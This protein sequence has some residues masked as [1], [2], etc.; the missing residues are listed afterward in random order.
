MRSLFLFLHS[1]VYTRGQPWTKATSYRASASFWLVSLLFFAGCSVPNLE[2]PGCVDS[3]NALREFY[4][5]HF[6]NNMAFTVDDLKAKEKFLTPEF[7]ARLRGSQEGID[8]FTTG[9]SDFPKAFRAGECRDITADRTGFD[10][11]LFWKDDTRS[12]ERK[13][14]VEMAKRG[15]TWLVDN[16]AAK[17]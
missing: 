7:A 17:N 14:N 2:S 1:S 3:R 4:S 16:I 8:P 10:V 11:V 12:E 5:Y 13:I 6:G 9:D 15:E